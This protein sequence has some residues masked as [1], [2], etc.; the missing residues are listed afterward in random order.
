MIVFYHDKDFVNLMLACTLPNVDN[1]C[2]HK[3]TNTEVYSSTEAD[4]DLLE[5]LRKVNDGGPL[6]VSHAKQLLMKP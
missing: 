6:I 3:S 4:E 1:I 2:F 5:K